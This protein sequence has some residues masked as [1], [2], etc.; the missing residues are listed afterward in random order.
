M[1]YKKNMSKSDKKHP[2]LAYFGMEPKS[3]VNVSQVPIPHHFTNSDENWSRYFWEITPDGHTQTCPIS[4][5]SPMRTDVGWWTLNKFFFSCTFRNNSH[6][7]TYHCK[8]MG[9]H[10]L[11]LFCYS[12]DL[13]VSM[14][15]MYVPSLEYMATT[16]RVRQ[17]VM[18]NLNWG[19]LTLA[20]YM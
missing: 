2:Y 5:S 16:H 9:S 18:M 11:H 10:C 4:R 7:S 15:T 8:G 14:A 12:L 17:L 3:V 6:N 20:I 19:V 1:H 13:L